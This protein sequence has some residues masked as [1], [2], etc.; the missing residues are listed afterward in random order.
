MKEFFSDTVFQKI[1][2]AH[3]TNIAPAN[4]FL[5]LLTG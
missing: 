3:N 4:P 2:N 5:I 1:K